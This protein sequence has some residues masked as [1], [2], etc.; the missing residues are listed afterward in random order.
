MITTFDDL[1]PAA[2]N[3]LKVNMGVK[4]GERVLFVSDAPAPKD[5]QRSSSLLETVIQEL[6]E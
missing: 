2:A 1:R 4:A 3:M 6:T 5:R